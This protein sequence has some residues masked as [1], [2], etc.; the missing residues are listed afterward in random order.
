MLSQRFFT[1]VNQVYMVDFDAGI[2]GNPANGANLQ[3]Q[4]QALGNSTLLD[5]TVSPP[6]AGTNDPNSVQFSHY[7]FIFTADSTVTTLKFTNVGLGN[8]G[9]DQILDLVSVAR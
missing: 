2:F 9:A 4:V 1:T 6:V 5:Q 3:L 7:H 8:S